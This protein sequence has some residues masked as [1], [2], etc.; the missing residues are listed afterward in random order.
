MLVAERAERAAQSVLTEDTG[1]VELGSGWWTTM[2]PGFRQ[3]NADGSWS[4]W[5]DDW[6]MEIRISDAAKAAHHEPVD[7]PSRFDPQDPSTTSGEGWQ[8]SRQFQL[9]LS[10]HRVVH[11]LSAR[12]TAGDSTLSLLA[13]CVGIGGNERAAGLLR[14]VAYR[15][16][17][18]IL[19]SLFRRRRRNG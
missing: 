8:G 14:A 3:R 17:T 5:G 12:L 16:S 2:P 1:L 4:I 11:H 19:R 7:S 15:P 9:E 18:S 6:S 10:G 13:C